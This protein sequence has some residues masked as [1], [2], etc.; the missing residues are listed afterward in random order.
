MKKSRLISAI[1]EMA[2]CSITKAGEEPVHKKGPRRL[3]NDRNTSLELVILI[4]SIKVSASRKSL[5]LN[6]TS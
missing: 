2:I 5:G 4:F 3:F 1:Q 6:M